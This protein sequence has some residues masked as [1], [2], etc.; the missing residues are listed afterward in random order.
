MASPFI[1]AAVAAGLSGG[2]AGQPVMPEG[3]GRVMTISGD[4]A[5]AAQQVVD[6]TGGVLLSARPSADGQ[7]CVVTVLI[8][9]SDNERPR[10]VQRQVPM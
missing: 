3:G 9:G 10:K 8:Q 2:L 7:S 6:E 5:S 1:I 4:C